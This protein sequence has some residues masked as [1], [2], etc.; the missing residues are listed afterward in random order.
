MIN[1]DTQLI[2]TSENISLFTI[3]FNWTSQPLKGNEEK[4]KYEEEWGNIGP[5][6]IYE[7]IQRN[8]TTAAANCVAKGG[9]LASVSSPAQ[10]KKLQ[11]FVRMVGAKQDYI[12]LGGTKRKGNWTWSDGSEWSEEHWKRN[13]YAHPGKNCLYL[14]DGKWHDKQCK[15]EFYSICSTTKEETK[16]EVIGGYTV[17]WHLRGK[18]NSTDNENI[19]ETGFWKVKEGQDLRISNWNLMFLMSLVQESKIANLAKERVRGAI[20]KYRWRRENILDSP[21][22][23]QSQIFDVIL[24]AG[25]D[26]DLKPDYTPWIRDNDIVFGF[27]LYSILHYCSKNLGD[28]AKMFVFFEHLITHHSLETVIAATMNSIPPRA[29]KRMQD[30]S[31]INMWYKQ[32]DKI[33]NF[34]LGPVQAMF[35][36]TKEL[37]I[38]NKLKPPF[39]DGFNQHGYGQECKEASCV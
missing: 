19:K 4:N 15:I 22:L 3:Q 7:K 17:N 11:A 28:A 36:S 23:N 6:L 33:Y 35:S 31:S 24:R 30:F 29:D 18:E 2:F 38:L 10:W 27:E 14:F 26:L 12:W 20:M 9:H 32:L 34:A 37:K 1:T 5:K 13:Y 16:T 25:H 39:L 21:C 8:W